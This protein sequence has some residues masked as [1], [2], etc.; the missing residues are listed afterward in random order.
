MNMTDIK[1]KAKELGLKAGRL[2][3]TD[4]IHLI[5]RKEGNFPCFETAKNKCDQLK[6]C[7]RDACLSSKKKK[8]PAWH[9]KKDTY[10]K[11]IAA[12]IK[13]RKS[14]LNDLDQ[15]ARKLIGKGK[16]EA[17]EEIKQLDKK[18]A[19]VKKSSQKLAANSEAAWKVAKKG[20]DAAWN[21]LSK[22]FS[23]AAKK[24]K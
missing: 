15:K 11:K 22:G 2:K 5:Q 10:A 8:H 21:D 24:F 13:E 1:N 23:K 3:K 7:W 4:L 14:Q 12:E 17:Q 19:E 6:C 9:K 18:L 20:I 16:K